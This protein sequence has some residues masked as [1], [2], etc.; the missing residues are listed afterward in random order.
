M[1][2]TIPTVLTEQQGALWRD[3]RRELERLVGVLGRWDATAEDMSILRQALAQLDELFLLVVAGEFNS[4]KSALINALLGERYLTEGVTPTTAE[5]NILRYGEKG[6]SWVERG[7]RV[8]TYPAPFLREINLVDTPGTNAVLREHEEIT[9]EFVPRSDLV[10][11]VTSADRPFTE[12]ERAF[13]SAIRAWGKKIVI[14]VNKVDIFEADSEQAQVLDF[15]RANARQLLGTSPEL[16]AL[17]ARLAL[18]AKTGA[19]PPA[20]DPAT[21]P[22]ADGADGNSAALVPAAP[23]SPMNAA[24]WQ[25]SQFE[26]FERYIH[27]TLNEQSRI[28][29]KL[30]NPLGVGQ[31]MANEYYGRMEDRRGLLRDDIQ[32]IEAVERQLTLYRE[33]MQAEFDRRFDRIDNTILEMRV[34]GEEFFDDQIRLRRVFDLL[35]SRRLGEDFEQIV[36]ADTPQIIETQVQELI[37]WMVERE[38]KEWRV[39]AREL[40]RRQRTEFLGSAAAEAAGGFEYNRRELLDSVG[41]A[42]QDIVAKYDREVES[43]TLVEGVQDA[44]AQTALAGVGAVSLGVILHAILASAAADATGILAAGVVGALGLAILPYKKSQAKKDLREKTDELRAR[45]R[46]SLETEFN[47]Q[48]DRSVE[49]LRE[50]IGPYSRFIRGEHERLQSLQAEM[51][52]ITRTLN[53]LRARIDTVVPEAVAG[54]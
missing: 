47:E 30:L 20:P 43:Q 26:P 13:L 35:N 46:S 10:L 5:I 17:S 37:D 33:D 25:A 28:R 41:K 49:R 38:L 44:L 36:V 31:K 18:R 1:I 6:K 3:E 19:R 54:D 12:S 4:G 7:I 9:R 16:F 21:P 8:L 27:E 48:I 14:V 24:W 29:L 32:T 51:D 15:V 53:E 11:F 40:G 2:T 23:L 45:L 50:A 34:R 39:I 52:E 42:A 22:P